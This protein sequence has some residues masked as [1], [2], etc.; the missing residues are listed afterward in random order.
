MGSHVLVY[1]YSKVNSLNSGLGY[2]FSLNRKLAGSQHS[3][4]GSMKRTHDF[5]IHTEQ[6]ISC[7]Q[8]EWVL[9]KVPGDCVTW[10]S[11]FV[12]GRCYGVPV[13]ES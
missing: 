7:V 8:S 10:I 3:L 2:E 9:S 13:A 4:Y 12:I 6:Q 1:E 11:L 5:D